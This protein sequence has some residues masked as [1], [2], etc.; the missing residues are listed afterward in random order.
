MLLKNVKVLRPKTTK[1]QKRNSISYVYQVVDQSY[2]KDKKYTVDGRKCIGKMIDD[3]YMIPNEYFSQYYPD[4]TI[5]L[6]PNP[7]SDTLSIGSFL[8]IHKLFKDTGVEGILKNIFDDGYKFIEDL[9]FYM[10]TKQ[11]CVFQHYY[12][13]MRS[14]PIVDS[15]LR[16]DTQISKFLKNEIKEEMINE[17]VEQWCQLNNKDDECIYIGYDSTN[18]NT[19]CKGIGLADYGHPKIDEGL[20][21]FNLAY[22]VKQL[23]T[24][25]LFYDLYDGSVNDNAQFSLM[26]QTAKSYG[27][28]KIGFLLDR[29]Y[30][31]EKNIKSMRNNG[32]QYMMMLK[33]NQTICKELHKQYSAT[34][35]TLEGY[36]IG[37]Y[38]LFGTTVKQQFYGKKDYFHIYY[39]DKQASEE[40]VALLSKYDVWEKEL[41][42]LLEKKITQKESLEKYKKVFT[43]RYD[44]NGYFISYRR[45]SEEIK[46]ELDEKGYFYIV[47]S[48]EMTT[49]KALAL[50]RGRDNIEKMFRSLKTGI[51][52]DK[53][54]VYTLES[55]KSKIFLTF[56]AMIIRNELFSR[57][58]ELRKKN[59]KDYTVPGIISELECVECT[60]DSLGKYRRRYALTSKQKQILEKFGIDEKYIDKSVSGFNY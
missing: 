10:V 43:L 47:T 53:A 18:F 56:I 3:E 14:H 45:K 49:E 5:E 36:F 55:L 40:K 26:I 25:P 58:E 8:V 4:V 60:K 9:V 6:P 32:Y 20:P 28:N 30:V 39:N 15:V 46:K 41:K 34:L 12:N 17:F 2:N 44:D 35:R 48:E 21:Q 7:F 57:V 27:Y 19:D 31:S 37:D 13:F 51:D 38:N 16:E 33:N 11:S 59:R 1:I 42:V 24:N 52:F 29:G 22:A 23:T 50:Y 54:R